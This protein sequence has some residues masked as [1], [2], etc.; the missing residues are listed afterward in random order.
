[1]TDGTRPRAREIAAA[2]R[3]GERSARSVVEESLRAIGA[4]ELELHACNLVLADEALAAADAVDAA[5][6]AR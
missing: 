2:V 3:A 4:R 5:V 6:G 1:M